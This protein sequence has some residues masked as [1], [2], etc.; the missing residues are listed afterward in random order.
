MADTIRGSVT[1]VIDDATFDMKV[2]QHG[3]NN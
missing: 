3:N 1:K 2:T